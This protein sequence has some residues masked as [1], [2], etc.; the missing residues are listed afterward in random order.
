MWSCRLRL[1][2]AAPRTRLAGSCGA[3]LAYTCHSLSPSAV[4]E[5]I[6]RCDEIQSAAAK[7]R[8]WRDIE[9]QTRAIGVRRTGCTAISQKPSAWRCNR[10]L[11]HGSYLL[12]LWTAPRALLTPQSRS[13]A[14]PSCECRPGPP[15]LQCRPACTQD[16]RVIETSRHARFCVS[17]LGWMRGR[18]YLS[19]QRGDTLC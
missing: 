14:S 16:M 11:L 10:L 12:V 13:A 7:V 9:R 4:F 8:Y 19:D 1:S 17:K 3:R 5:G 15:Q 6:Q 2:R 18:Q